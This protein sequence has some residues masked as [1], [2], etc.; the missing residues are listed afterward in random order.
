ML[1]QLSLD[2]IAQYGNMT[3]YITI[4][5]ISRISTPPGGIS[6]WTLHPCP[7]HSPH[8]TKSHRGSRHPN[9]VM[10]QSQST[11]LLG[12]RIYFTY[13]VYGE[14]K[15][16]IKKFQKKVSGFKYQNLQNVR[17]VLEPIKKRRKNRFGHPNQNFHY[18]GLGTRNFGLGSGFSIR[19][20][21]YEYF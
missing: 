16:I 7:T 1:R 19:A 21:G 12:A 17:T 13:K 14:G 9:K 20:I 2:I 18:F 8:A 3:K 4:I 5:H 10:K 11:C 15:I 6:L